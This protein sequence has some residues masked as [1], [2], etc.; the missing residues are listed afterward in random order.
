VC[1]D[2][3]V[4]F[5]KESGPGIGFWISVALGAISGIAAL[6]LGAGWLLSLVIFVIVSVAMGLLL[7]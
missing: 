3:R 5:T 2:P 4:G 7:S 6:A 1:H